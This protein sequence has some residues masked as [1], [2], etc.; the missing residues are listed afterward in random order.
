M[1]R[2]GFLPSRTYPAKQQL[3]PLILAGHDYKAEQKTT[4]LGAQMWVP[5]RTLTPGHGSL[6]VQGVTSALL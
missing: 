1:R 2:C 5:T 3:L 4:G 6:Y